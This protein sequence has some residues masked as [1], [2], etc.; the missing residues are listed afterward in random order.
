MKCKFYSEEI[1]KCLFDG[2]PDDCPFEDNENN[3]TCFEPIKGSKNMKK[4]NSYIESKL[5]G[6]LPTEIIS[7][8]KLALDNS[9][10]AALVVTR[11]TMTHNIGYSVIEGDL[12]N[13]STKLF[14]ELIDNLDLTVILY[15]YKDIEGNYFSIPTGDLEM[16]AVNIRKGALRLTPDGGDTID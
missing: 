16:A 7:N 13:A 14:S 3:C 10:E 11:D 15:I 5:T 1:G 9:K 2:P 8:L 6:Y 12:H 4:C